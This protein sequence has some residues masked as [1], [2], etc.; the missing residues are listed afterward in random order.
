[1]KLGRKQVWKL[2]RTQILNIVDAARDQSDCDAAKG[3]IKALEGWWCGKN[4]KV[5]KLKQKPTKTSKSMSKKAVKV[6]ATKIATDVLGF[7]RLLR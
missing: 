2:S 1:M 4:P 5:C 6:K 3:F 7:V